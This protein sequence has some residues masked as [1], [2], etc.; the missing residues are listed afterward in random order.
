[1]DLAIAEQD[2]AT[3]IFLQWFVSEQVEEESSVGDVLNKLRLIQNDSSGLFMLDDEMVKR[4]FV[5][6]A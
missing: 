5:L 4:V 6:P 3:K 1:M 2:H